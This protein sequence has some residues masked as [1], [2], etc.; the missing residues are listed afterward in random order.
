MKYIIR[1]LFV[2]IAAMALYAP[3][4]LAQTRKLITNLTPYTVYV[5]LIIR[6]SA[7]PR[8]TAGTKD[9]TLP[10]NTA[11]WV[12]Y[13]D[14]INIYLNGVRL[15]AIHDGEIVRSQDVV[16]TRGS[17]IDNML[18]ISN[19]LDIKIVHGLNFEISTR[20]VH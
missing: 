12:E 15:T 9:F 16:V 11:H 10:P 8:D 19:A 2:L 17:H 18:N 20:Q 5:D 7:D 3:D 1:S 6:R 13:G 14:R 4:T